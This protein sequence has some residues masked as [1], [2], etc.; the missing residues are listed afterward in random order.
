MN[1][2]YVY[3]TQGTEVDG[4]DVYA[5]KSRSNLT[6]ALLV[7]IKHGACLFS[8]VAYQPRTDAIATLRS[9]HVYCNVTRL[10]V[11]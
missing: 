5:V 2:M 4:L 1:V 9:T 8:G 7:Q 6:E 11:M 3:Q 10:H